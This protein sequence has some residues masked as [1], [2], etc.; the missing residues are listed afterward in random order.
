MTAG[1]WLWRGGPQR[2]AGRGWRG[3]SSSD[4]DEPGSLWG[5]GS[6]LPRWA[7]PADP[8]PASLRHGASPGKSGACCSPAVTWQIPLGSALASGSV[9]E[10][11]RL[12][13]LQKIIL[14]WRGFFE[15]TVLRRLLVDFWRLNENSFLKSLLTLL[16]KTLYASHPARSQWL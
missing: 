6:R 9:H 1:S 11:F 15:K 13:F 4:P 2:E 5:P 3:G 12:G 16:S 8:G 14:Q 7:A 10:R